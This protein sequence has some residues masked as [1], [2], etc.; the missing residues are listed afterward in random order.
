MY[1]HTGSNL[2]GICTGCI[3]LICIIDSLL[4][5]YQNVLLCIQI[6]NLSVN[7][8][9]HQKSERYLRVCVFA[10]DMNV[11]TPPQAQLEPALVQTNLAV[12]PLGKELHA[13]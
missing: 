11:R 5:L 3:V 13:K 1:V 2:L 10:L 4:A 7:Q 8:F 12:A 6:F 9:L